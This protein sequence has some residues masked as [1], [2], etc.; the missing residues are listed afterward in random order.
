M[1]GFFRAPGKTAAPP[2]SGFSLENPS[3]SVKSPCLTTGLPYFFARF[4]KNFGPGLQEKDPALN[5]P[6]FDLEEAVFPDKVLAVD[7]ASG[8][9][10]HSA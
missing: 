9:G 10:V 2:Q 6:A 3:S 8:V 1:R 4:K 7:E 5:S